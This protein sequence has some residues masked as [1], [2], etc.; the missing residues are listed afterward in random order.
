MRKQSIR[1][2][3]WQSATVTALDMNRHL[4]HPRPECLG[5][6]RRKRP[7]LE[8]FLDSIHFY[9]VHPP[10]RDNWSAF[11][12]LPNSSSFG[13]CLIRRP[14]GQGSARAARS[15]ALR[16]GPLCRLFR[17]KTQCAR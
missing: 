4:S 16:E 11:R 17:E 1:N 14:N 9:V 7:V 12:T 15:C 5:T 10:G 6:E 2:F 13:S 8:K 3:Q